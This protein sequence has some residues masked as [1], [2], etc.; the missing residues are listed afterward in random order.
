MLAVN[1][2]DNFKTI[3]QHKKNRV[4]CEANSLSS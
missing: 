4:Y 1:F 2:Y 3:D